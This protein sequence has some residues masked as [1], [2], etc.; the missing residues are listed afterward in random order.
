MNVWVQK[1]ANKKKLNLGLAFYAKTFTLK[2]PNQHGLGAPAI[3]IGRLENT[4]EAGFL[5][6]NEVC[7]LSLKS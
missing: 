7:V 6:Y 4:T 5:L 2:D 1:G 3:G